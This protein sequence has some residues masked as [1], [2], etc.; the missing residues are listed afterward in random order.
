ML[1]KRTLCVLGSKTDMATMTLEEKRLKQ[2]KQQ[3]FGKEQPLTQKV[4][5]KELKS[6][7]SFKSSAKPSPQTAVIDSISLKSDLM[8]I[9]LLSALAI[10]IQFSLYFAIQNGL[11]RLW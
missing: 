8:K 10:L 2:L 7:A 6:I 5:L 11:L 1:D 4:T 9:T 3:L